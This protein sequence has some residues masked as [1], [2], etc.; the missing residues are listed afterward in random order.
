VAYLGFYKGGCLT[1]SAVV[2]GPSFAASGA[3]LT[4]GYHTGTASL[5]AATVTATP[6]RI[7]EIQHKVSE[8]EHSIDRALGSASCLEQEL[9]IQL[10]R[11]PPTCIRLI[12]HVRVTINEY[13]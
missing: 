10:L 7:E 3:P 12:L 6:Q 13:H 2:L 4:F 11:D 9:R 8:V 1:V 5:G